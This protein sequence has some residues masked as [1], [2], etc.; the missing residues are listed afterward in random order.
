[1]PYV[2]HYYED[3]SAK[4][5]DGV[6]KNNYKKIEEAF[7]EGAD[8]NMKNDNG[9][10]FF[11]VASGHGNART[12]NV[13]LEKGI[14]VNITDDY[15]FNN[16]TA[17]SIAVINAKYDVVELLIEK[18]ADI[19]KENNKGD[20]PLIHAIRSEDYNM[21]Q[22][23]LEH[24]YINIEHY[25]D[26]IFN[27]LRVVAE[28]TLIPY[29]IEKYIETR[30]QI[31]KQKDDNIEEII[32]SY[33]THISSLKTMAYH[34]SPTALDTYINLNPGTII[35]PYGKL[36]GRRRTITRKYER[37]RPIILNL[38]GCKRN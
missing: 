37:S 19:N 26:T 32:K 35:R 27:Q 24:P 6:Y 21:V 30:D 31:K 29:L 28:V 33:T 36:G 34:L 22:L 1:M 11:I 9:V 5:W 3:P 2:G 17:L 16:N 18:G 7:K 10:W 12:V 23:L 14:D 8:V 25:V 15:N 38:Q 20:T 4:L 13:L